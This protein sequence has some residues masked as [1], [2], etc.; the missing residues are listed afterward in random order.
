MEINLL[1]T[2]FEKLMSEGRGYCRVF[3][4]PSKTVG[5]DTVNILYKLLQNNA[6]TNEP[7]EGTGLKRMD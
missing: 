6:N 3:C 7:R 1:Q 5:L 2:N 4:M